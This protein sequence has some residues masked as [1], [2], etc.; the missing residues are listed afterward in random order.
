MTV[1]IV[2]RVT[3]LMLEIGYYNELSV[4]FTDNKAMQEFVE[5]NNV[6]TYGTETMV[7]KRA[8]HDKNYKIEFM[9]MPVDIL[10]K[11]GTRELV[12]YH[13]KF[14]VGLHEAAGVVCP[15]AQRPFC[16]LFPQCLSGKSSFSRAF[17]KKQRR[18]R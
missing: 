5:G 11:P 12:K 13:E 18:T 9:H 1:K 6:Q 17:F 16:A 7:Y 10:T 8:I 4:I 15:A 14:M 3:N 2:N